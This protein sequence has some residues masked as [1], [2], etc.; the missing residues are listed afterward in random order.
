MENIETLPKRVA[1]IGAGPA[2]LTAAYTLLKKDKQM[3]VTVLEADKEY[4][5]GI[6]R[7]VKYKDFRFDI[8]GHRFFSKSKE[9]EDFWT[10]ILPRDMLDRPRSSRIF[11]R[12]KFFSY[13]LKAFEALFKLGV[14]ESVFCMASYGKARILPVKDPKN[15]EDWVSNQF[16]KR[17]FSI[18]FKTYTEKV[19]GMNCKDI[20][21]DWAAQR[22]KGLS[23]ASAIKNALL[24]KRKPKTKGEVIKT[25]ID[26]FRYP[27]LGPGMMWEVCA[28]KIEEMGGSVAMGTRVAACDWNEQEKVWTVKCVDANGRQSEIQAEHVISSAPMRE[29]C[30][31]LTPKMSDAAV[32]AAGSLRYRDFL[33]V[34]LIVK[35]KEQFS[36]NWIYIHDPKVKVGRVQN[37]KSWSPEMV[38]DPEMSCYGLEYFCF[39]GDGL[40]NATDEDLIKLAKQEIAR[41]GLAKE[42]DV[43]DGCVVR[44]AKAYPIYDD[45]YAAHVQTLKTE[46]EAKFPTLH[47]MGR[48]GMH[49]YNNQDHAMMTAMLCAENILAEKR[50]Y[51]VWQVNEDADYHEEGSRGEQSSVS[52]LRSVPTRA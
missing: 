41:I 18:F 34:A 11:Y 26:T 27:R 25:L 29:L 24:P 12:G 50:L 33:T 13:P 42:V 44:Q 8:G 45:E 36:D 19:W 10:E 52:G 14:L 6:S 48:N 16:G 23:L 35:D 4:V 46:M 31:S 22:I 32:N 30:L 51:D 38:P 3:K 7:T 20:S 5:G 40:W 2:G 9:V 47:V 28:E 1:I 37:F 15:F 17:L 39:K 43:V 21:A 49:K